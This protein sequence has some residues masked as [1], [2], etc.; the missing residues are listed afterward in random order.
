ML[1][2]KES[3]LNEKTNSEEENMETNNRDQVKVIRSDNT[4][5]VYTSECEVYDKLPPQA[6][7]VCFHQMSGYWLENATLS[8]F[9]GKV[10]GD[11][12]RRVDKVFK[13]YF[14]RK[15]CNTGVLMSG[16]KGCGKS[17]TSKLIAE[18]AIRKYGL[19]VVFVKGDIGSDLV[20]YLSTINMDCVLV[21][22]EFDK[23][24][25]NMYTVKHDCEGD[26]EVNKQDKF[27]SFLDGVSDRSH[28]LIV[29]T[30][31]EVRRCSDFLI[32]RP[33]RMFYHFRFSAPSKDEARVYYTE[34]LD[35]AH[36]DLIDR[37]IGITNA[38]GLSYDCME[39]ICFE[40]NNG[41]SVS[42][43]LDDLNI[44]CGFGCQRFKCHVYLKD[45]SH[46]STPLTVD[47]SDGGTSQWID[48]L[49]DNGSRVRGRIS[50]MLSDM[51]F[52]VDTSFF[53]LKK[54]EFM[55]EECGER[56]NKS[57]VDKI[58]LETDN[59]DAS[60]S[61]SVLNMVGGAF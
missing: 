51:E 12:E 19:P 30:C 60:S 6:Y 37:L 54:F 39:A 56:I 4:Y 42:N 33:G 2:K 20:G 9:D 18:R 48:V 50:F 24:F 58:V 27:L 55:T 17:M 7:K 38:I 59:Y 46:A 23:M 3:K 31:N 5:R 26:E 13:T 22:D 32:N 61:M 34:K 28:K 25:P 57:E 14:M 36:H 8:T 21:F 40:I 49:T 1:G 47:R 10:Y 35:A 53:K 41:E 11:I 29:C 44:L 15:G 52:D 16:M 45:G 43:V